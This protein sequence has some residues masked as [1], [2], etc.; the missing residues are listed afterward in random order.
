MRPELAKIYRSHCGNAVPV[1]GRTESR[2]SAG[3]SGL[4]IMMECYLVPIEFIVISLFISDLILM[5]LQR[6]NVGSVWNIFIFTISALL[7]IAYWPV[8]YNGVSDSVVALSNVFESIFVKS[9]SLRTSRLTHPTVHCLCTRPRPG[10]RSRR[11]NQNT[12]SDIGRT[13]KNTYASPCHLATW[14]RGKRTV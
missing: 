8:L 10:P 12:E 9:G 2:R 13:T 4:Y 3:H 6:Q 14:L 7:T 1:G 11:Y 5:P